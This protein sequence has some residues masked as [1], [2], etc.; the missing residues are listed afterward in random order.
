MTTDDLKLQRDGHL[1]YGKVPSSKHQWAR[2][3]YRVAEITETSMFV[4]L[5]DGFG[6][7]E[8]RRS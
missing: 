8:Y 2:P 4:T 3:V 1:E 7:L 6:V 5:G